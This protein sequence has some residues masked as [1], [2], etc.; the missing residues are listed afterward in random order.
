MM[1]LMVVVGIL[2]FVI[3]GLLVAYVNRLILNEYNLKFSVAMNL[4]RQITEDV[5]YHRS[6]WHSIQDT[7]YSVSKI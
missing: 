5:Y 2:V 4:V 3:T 6:D 1:E 7:S